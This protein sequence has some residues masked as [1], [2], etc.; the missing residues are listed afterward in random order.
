MKERQE[1][2]TSLQ[3]VLY[4]RLILT[5]NV[6]RQL[7]ESVDCFFLLVHIRTHSISHHQCYNTH[8]IDQL[9]FFLPKVGSNDRDRVDMA[10]RVI[11]DH[12]RTLSVA[13]CD[14][15][16]PGSEGRGY[17]VRRILR[18]AV[19]FGRQFLNAPKDTTWFC[20]LVHVVVDLLGEVFPEL[21]KD[22]QSIETVLREEEIQFSR[23]LDRVG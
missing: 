21:R 3:V 7:P 2:D 11:A 15:A 5:N 13:I 17:V 4:H 23:T 14:G 9:A 19:R 8:L 1:E 12:I 22:P 10:Y 6:G 16:L 20:G 18:R